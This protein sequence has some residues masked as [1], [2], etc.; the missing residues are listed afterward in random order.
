MTRQQ[1]HI[2]AEPTNQSTV[3][4]GSGDPLLPEYTKWQDLADF[5]RAK[6]CPRL[7]VYVSLNGPKNTSG[8][9]RVIGL[10][11]FAQ[12][13]RVLR[14]CPFMGQQ[15]IY[16]DPG[17]NYTHGIGAILIDTPFIKDQHLFLPMDALSSVPSP[18]PTMAPTMGDTIWVW[19]HG[20]PA[21]Q[22]SAF[23]YSATPT[24]PSPLVP[25]APWELLASRYS[26]VMPYQPVMHLYRPSPYQPHHHQTQPQTPHIPY[27]GFSQSPISPEAD[28]YQQAQFQHQHAYPHHVQ[29]PSQNI[30]KLIITWRELQDLSA[31]PQTPYVQAWN[32]S[33]SPWGIM[34]STRTSPVTRSGRERN[35]NSNMHKKLCTTIRIALSSSMNDPTVMVMKCSPDTDTVTVTF[36]TPQHALQAFHELSYLEHISVRFPYGNEDLGYLENSRLMRD[37]T[38]ASIHSKRQSQHYMQPEYYDHDHGQYDHHSPSHSHPRDY[39]NKRRPSRQ[40]QHYHEQGTIVT[41]TVPSPRRW[42]RAMK[43]PPEPQ[44]LPPLPVHSHAQIQSQKHI[45]SQSPSPSQPTT[46]YQPQ[47]TTT[48]TTPTQTT[49]TTGEA[50]TNDTSRRGSAAAVLIVDGSCRQR[51]AQEDP[52]QPRRGSEKGVNGNGDG[53]TSVIVVNGSVNVS[54]SSMTHNTARLPG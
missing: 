5:L 39:Y 32:S 13:E 51:G 25:P 29:Q 30:L 16:H 36:R 11:I 26:P 49:T 46:Q 1:Q 10:E 53:N 52:P 47:T 20:T 50:V 33:L 8:W 6:V 2:M 15:I 28:Q 21:P 4:V 41:V 48:T 37:C 9:V 14:E 43:P 45:P 22:A 18:S 44:L 40:H 35:D 34:P 12:V 38:H 7:D 3:L 17:Y 42:R 27:L 23:P 31:S 19:P 24:S 54:T